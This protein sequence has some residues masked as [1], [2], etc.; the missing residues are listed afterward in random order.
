MGIL[1]N[2]TYAN[3]AN[4]AALFLHLTSPRLADDP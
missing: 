3:T 1:V 4:I 2:P